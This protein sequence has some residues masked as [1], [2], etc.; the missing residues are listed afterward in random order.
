[1]A[2]VSPPCQG[3]SKNGRGKLL[4]EI[5]AGRRPKED[6]R[7]A[8]II[9][10]VEIIST[11]KPETIVF[12]NVIE[13]KNTLISINKK[14]LLITDYIKEKLPEYI[15][16][17]NEVNF[18]DYGVP[19][20]RKRLITIVTKNKKFINFYNKFG[21]LIPETTHSKQGKDKKKWI[22]VKDKIFGLEK[23]DGKS[24]L[25]SENDPL[26]KIVKL[27]D[28]KYW[29]VS[30]TPSNESAFNKRI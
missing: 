25:R 16:D 12:E 28:R 29:W 27:D 17:V 19:Q 26:H 5:K 3:M 2:L 23:L 14:A 22:S 18:A 6:P 13:M 8:L 24:K 9:P 10:A 30:N 4:S 1:M 7:N 20:N 15:V 11:L 21:T